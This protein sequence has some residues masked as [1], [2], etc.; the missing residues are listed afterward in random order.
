GVSGIREPVAPELRRHVEDR[1]ARRAPLGDDLDHAVRG[2]G[3]VEGSGGR[4]LD[5]LDA[6]DILRVDV[7]QARGGATRTSARDGAVHPD[8]IDVHDG[9]V[10]DTH[11]GD[12]A[13][14]D[15]GAAEPDLTRAEVR[16]KARHP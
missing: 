3:P 12:A 6:L 4:S 14:A 11:A 13:D 10:R 9:I 2:F 7:V 15:R 5:D 16:L 1:S 8:A